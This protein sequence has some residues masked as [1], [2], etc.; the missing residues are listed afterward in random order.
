M[1]DYYRLQIS[2]E[3]YNEI[4]NTFKEKIEISDSYL[5][6]KNYMEK[7]SYLEYEKNKYVSAK[8]EQ[9][10][11][12]EVE[13]STI[14]GFIRFLIQIKHLDP[15]KVVGAIHEYYDYISS[16]NDNYLEKK[17]QE[18]ITKRLEKIAHDNGDIL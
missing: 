3:M 17:K 11:A 4:I 14:D 1:I 15:D 16:T 5:E 12:V 10:Y 7:I 13:Q 2:N 6:I 9:D 18:D 8:R